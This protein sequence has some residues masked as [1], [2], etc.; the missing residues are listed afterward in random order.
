M[1]VLVSSYACKDDDDLNP[2]ELDGVAPVSATFTTSYEMGWQDSTRRFE[3]DTFV[4][5]FSIIFTAEQE[6][7]SYQWII[8]DDPKVFDTK[9]FT[10]RFDDVVGAINVQL[11]IEATPN[12]DCF[13]ADDGRD[14]ISSTIYL[15]EKEDSPI[16]G[17]YRGIVNSAPT[18][19][20]DIDIHLIPPFNDDSN[21]DNLPK[22]CIRDEIY[23]LNF[24]LGYRNLAMR[25]LENYVNCPKPQGWGDLEVNNRIT[26]EY[27]IWDSNIQQHVS[28]IFT[29]KKIN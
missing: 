28:D 11:V 29:G 27:T 15:I 20:F 19:T 1:I 14:T 23:R 18:D 24:S 4:N 21:I 9:E 2:C 17:K 3:G 5:S 10:L 16:L 6:A 7:D 25:S 12:L 13:P 26:L 22:G 8:G